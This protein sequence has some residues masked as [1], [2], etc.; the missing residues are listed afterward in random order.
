MR[1]LFLKKKKLATASLV[2]GESGMV[3]VVLPVHNGAALLRQ[4]VESCI[5]QEFR[6]WE[7]IIV[8]D[9]STD[10]TPLIIEAFVQSD[11]RIRSLTARQNVG[12]PA[13]LN[14]GFGVA[15]GEFYTWTSDDNCFRPNCLGVLAAELR[16]HPAVDL[17][18][19]N[20]TTIDAAGVEGS[21]INVLA[22][23]NLVER[24]CIG[25]SFMFRRNV[26]KVLGG[27][28]KGLFLVEDYDFWLRASC[29]FKFM[30]VH[31]DLYLYRLHESSLTERRRDEVIAM[32]ESLL[33]RRI[34]E[35]QWVG[36][37]RQATALMNIAERCRRRS[38]ISGVKRLFWKAFFLS[39]SE[40]FRH[41]DILPVLSLVIGYRLA[42]LLTGAKSQ[43]GGLRT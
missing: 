34:V 2:A 14:M 30:P 43:M 15:R 37:H 9:A 40:V 16:A 28:D 12:L 25:S 19:S 7:L 33:E 18:Y 17:V 36:R 11:S 4:A 24:N 29:H 23:E 42:C 38:N 39:P 21:H 3:S 41:G 13:A 26:F 5:A 27:Y 10:E 35:M 8:D 6:Q 1:G 31:Q 20:Y 22:P 32:T